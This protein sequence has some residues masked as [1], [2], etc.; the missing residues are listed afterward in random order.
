MAAGAV[1][2]SHHL[3][4][5]VPLYWNVATTSVPRGAAVP[6]S[7]RCWPTVLFVGEVAGSTENRND[8]RATALMAA[9]SDM[10]VRSGTMSVPVAAVSTS[11]RAS[12]ATLEEK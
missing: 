10:S 5:R 11:L 8:D 2:R 12:A 6:G 9:S 7:G 4:C 3:V 1:P